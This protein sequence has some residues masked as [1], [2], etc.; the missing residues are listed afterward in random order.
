MLQKPANPQNVNCQEF[1]QHTVSQHN[2]P[3]EHSYTQC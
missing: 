2:V 1:R 3:S